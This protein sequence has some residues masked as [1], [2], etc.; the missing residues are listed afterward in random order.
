MLYKSCTKCYLLACTMNNVPSPKLNFSLFLFTQPLSLWQILNALLYS[1]IIIK[2]NKY[3][4]SCYIGVSA[5]TYGGA[6]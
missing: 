3:Q 4:L 2:F 6:L 5:E 1:N